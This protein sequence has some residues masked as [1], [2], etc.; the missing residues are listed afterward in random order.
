MLAE[1]RAIS[2]RLLGYAWNKIRSSFASCAREARYAIRF[3]DAK[4]AYGC[5]VDSASCLHRNSAILHDCTV[6]NSQIGICSYLSPRCHLNNTTVG[7]YSSIGREAI[8]G[9]GIHP[10]EFVSTSPAFYRKS[11]VTGLELVECDVPFV[12]YKRILIG[13]DVWIG[14]RAVVLDGV[15]IGD[16][17]IV[18]ACAVVTKDVPPFAIVAG[19]PAKILRYRF[20]ENKIR[21]LMEL[22]WWDWPPEKIKARLAE[23]ECILKS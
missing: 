22:Q 3:T 4:I 23:L 11:N 17:A 21:K 13:N 10:T 16:G 14:A 20:S 7:R 15:T 1:L 8:C 5:V 6:I 12:E 9:L 2:I 19:V 18:G